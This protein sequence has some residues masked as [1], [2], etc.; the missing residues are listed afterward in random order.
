MSFFENLKNDSLKARGQSTFAVL[1]N[2]QK[3]AQQRSIFKW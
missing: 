2:T 1:E 3:T